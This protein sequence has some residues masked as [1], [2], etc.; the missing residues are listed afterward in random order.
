MLKVLQQDDF[1]EALTW[2]SY[3]GLLFESHRCLRLNDSLP[4]RLTPPEPEPSEKLQ[5]DASTSSSA[6]S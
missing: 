2:D 3:E 5:P 4:S 1:S 6:V